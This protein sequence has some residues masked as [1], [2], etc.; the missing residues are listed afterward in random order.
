MSEE[1]WRCGIGYCEQAE[2]EI[3]MP[4]LFDLN[5][6]DALPRI[7]VVAQDMAASLKHHGELLTEMKA[8]QTGKG[9]P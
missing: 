3:T 9:N 4:T 1:Y 8:A 6:L 5:A 7:L 2:R